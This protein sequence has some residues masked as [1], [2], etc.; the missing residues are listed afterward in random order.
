VI[1]TSLSPDPCT[2]IGLYEV[3]MPQVLKVLEI[4]QDGRV[5]TGLGNGF[6]P[7]AFLACIP[8]PFEVLKPCIK[9]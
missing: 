7:V 3:D 8:V 4:E 6:Q 2:A 9:V 5:F 1:V